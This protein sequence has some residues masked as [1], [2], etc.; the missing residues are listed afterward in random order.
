MDISVLGIG[1]IIGATIVVI[2]NIVL[3]QRNRK[4]D[5][6]KEQLIHLYNPLNALINKKSKY[7]AYLKRNTKKS[8]QY[9]VEYYKFFM[10]LQDIYLTNEVYASLDLHAAFHALHHNHEREYHNYSQ[11]NEDEE[12]I[13]KGIANFELSHQIDENGNSEIER[14]MNKFIEVL[15]NDL[16]QIYHQKPVYRFFRGW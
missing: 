16:Y 15:N 6:A 4:Y 10:E 14:K 13:L 12:D 11:W 2:T 9:P 7:L 8:N 3:H 1:G 5:I